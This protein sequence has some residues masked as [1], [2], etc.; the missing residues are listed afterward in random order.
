MPL[1]EGNAEFTHGV[2]EQTG[3]IVTALGISFD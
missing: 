1:G 3:K 2:M